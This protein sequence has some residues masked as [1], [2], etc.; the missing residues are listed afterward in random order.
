MR[1]STDARGLG[2]VLYDPIIIH[3]TRLLS[4]SHEDKLFIRP[5]IKRTKSHE[6]PSSR[7]RNHIPP[8]TRTLRSTDYSR[9]RSNEYIPTDYLRTA[10][11]QLKQ[12][13]R[14]HSILFSYNLYFV[15]KYAINYIN[16]KKK[17]Y[18]QGI[19]ISKI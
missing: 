16:I 17:S 15:Q 5:A 9:S 19:A 7:W 14:F 10:M 2:P 6:G 8:A 13:V 4:L 1:F 3:R 18:S 12:F 11:H